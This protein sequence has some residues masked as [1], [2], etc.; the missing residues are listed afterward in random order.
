MKQGLG[1]LLGK[2]RD[3]GGKEERRKKKEERREI[4]TEIERRE[5]LAMR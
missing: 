4:E 5:K 1:R 3:E 2:V